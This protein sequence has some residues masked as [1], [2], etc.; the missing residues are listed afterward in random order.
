MELTSESLKSFIEN[1]INP[2]VQG[3]GGE[4]TFISFDKNVLSIMVQG[5]C[6]RC[7][8]TAGCFKDWMVQEI[9]KVWHQEVKVKI[10]VKK[11]YFWDK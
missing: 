11:P 8:L 3:D 2:R 6:S 9:G 1:K 5:E 4:V 10:I 7:P